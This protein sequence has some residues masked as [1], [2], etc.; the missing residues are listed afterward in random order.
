MRSRTEPFHSLE[1]LEPRTLLATV[2]W[3]GGGGDGAWHNPLNWAGDVLPGAGDDVVLDR[4]GN[5]TI[6]HSQ[7]TT[8]V[9][10]IRSAETLTVSGGALMTAVSI[11][12][13]GPLNQSGGIVAGAGHLDIGAGFNWT[14][15][16]VS[17]AG[18][19]RLGPGGKLRVAGDVTL[20]RRLVNNGTITWASGNWKFVN[21]TLV[22]L[23]GRTFNL[24][25]TGTIISQHGTNV[26]TNS[27][28]VVRNGASTTASTV[29]VRLNSTGTIEARAG[30]LTLFGGGNASAG[31]VRAGVGTTITLITTNYQVGSNATLDGGGAVR[32]A[33]G[34]HHVL[35]TLG[36]LGLLALSS[37]GL[38]YQGAGSVARF[39]MESGLFTRDGNLTVTQSLIW[40]A[41][42]IAGDG[43]LVIADGATLGASGGAT[44]GISGTLDNRGDVLWSGGT[45][46]FTNGTVINKSE[47]ST[48][49]DRFFSGGGVNRFINAGQF[50]KT[51]GSVLVLDQTVG[52]VSLTN[53][54]AG[55]I[56]VQAGS[57]RLQGG[58]TNQGTITGQAQSSLVF[59]WTSFTLGG[60]TVSGF[61]SVA[62]LS[63]VRWTG[64]TIEGDGLLIVAGSGSLLLQ[65]AGTK[66][67]KRSVAN[68]GAVAWTAGDWAWNFV[69]VTN[70]SQGELE[71]AS[72]G[73][74]I[75]TGGQSNLSNNGVITKSG[76]G[77]V[78]LGSQTI[79]VS[80]TGTLDVEGGSLI[81]NGTRL[82]NFGSGVL[83][84]GVWEVRPGATLD[85]QQA[86]IQTAGADIRIHGSGN[87]TNLATLRGNSGVILLGEGANLQITP[88]VNG[89]FVNGGRII[90]DSTS[91]MSV[92]G[93]ITLAVSSRLEIDVAAPT[94][95]ARLTATQSVNLG[96][97]VRGKYLE[98]P[99]AGQA[100]AFI[101]GASRI[102]TFA[103]GSATGLPGSLRQAITYQ[104]TGSRFEILT[105]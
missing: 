63:V 1:P 96:G 36:G 88:S 50:T 45:L 78:N 82:S 93:S 62:I 101:T 72:S 24:Q 2:T 5:L 17:G 103:S 56:T 27:G 41:G 94:Q 43:S 90:V 61:P 21:V 73:T 38:N 70:S 20:A 81:L 80:N 23:A 89:N 98:T 3:D 12:A 16:Q 48:S 37:G 69:S 84:G 49:T 91:R 13:L 33:G 68:S 55:T 42:T 8:F 39:M 25:S 47:W 85:I 32:L 4:P 105:A 15:G 29:G 26:I 6:T 44:K 87:F 58:G 60:G 54:E 22:N 76:G 19:L 30:R 97:D 28:T 95:F 40:L 31:T 79:N 67:L 9:R 7:G 86:D 99:A 10:S 59:D 35:G 92:T 57:L 102:G 83:S 66:T 75:A 34:N 53:Q 74:L 46:K 52:G 51:G 71:L 104:P 18:D 65:G 11:N 100:F 14:G 64:G 77:T